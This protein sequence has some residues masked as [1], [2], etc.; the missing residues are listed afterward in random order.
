MIN[1]AVVVGAGFGGIAVALRLRKQGFHVTLVEK[2]HDLGGRALTW[3]SQGFVFDMGPTVITAPFLIDELFALFGKRRDDYVEFRPVFPWYRIQ[4]GDG[5]IFDYGG[6]LEQT[7]AQIGQ[8]SVA[9]Q[10][11]Y[12]RFLEK[13]K[14]IFEIGFLKY[15]DTP[16]CSFGS[17]FKAAPAM[18]RLGSHRSVYSFVS[19]YIS[20]ERLRR[21]F[22]FQ[23]L[24]VGGNPFSTTNIYSLIHYLE[25]QYGVYFCM[26]G[27]A[28]L[29]EGLRKLLIEEGIEVLLDSQVDTVETSN[30]QVTGV[31]LSAG[32]SIPAD[33]VVWNGCPSYLYKHA[34]PG[35]KRRRWTDKRISHMKHSMGLFVLYLG[36]NN[37]YRD[38]AHHTIVL[39]DEYEELLE[40]IFDRKV[41]SKDIS[42]YLHVP[43]RTD[44]SLAPPGGETVYVLCPVPNLEADID[45]AVEG[46]RLRDQI[47]EL[48]ERRVMPDLSKY[49]VTEKFITPE[50]FEKNLLSE[51]GAGFSVQP[52]LLQ[53]A[54]FRYHNRSEEVSGLFLAGAGTHPGA[55]IP[56]VL[57]SAKVTS[58]VVQEEF[59]PFRGCSGGVEV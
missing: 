6:T 20:D 12:L 10:Q 58:K 7:L 43:T 45:W 14:E 47:V 17:L 24:L 54:F 31:R 52:T 28:A 35:L 56:G 22:S 4:F 51:Y 18:I 11:G 55:G 1:R 46:V 40:R 53:S 50:Y 2:N 41:L 30:K 48:L 33:L 57:C 13:C 15:G 8:F 42:I 23:P 59:A 9:D 3:R 49:I 36:L 32:M 39:G 19:E 29:I 38:I 26:G 44:P 21:A 25:R 5:S 34:L 16:F 27:T 37:Q